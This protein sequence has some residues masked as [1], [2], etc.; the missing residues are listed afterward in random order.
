MLFLYVKRLFILNIN[1][2]L[3][4]KIDYLKNCGVNVSRFEAEMLLAEAIGIERKD[5]PL[6]K[7]SL[8]NEIL[9]RF[10]YFIAERKKHKPVDK[11]I[12]QKGFYKYDFVV[13]EDVL[14]PRFDTEILVEKAV[15]LLKGNS[16]AKILEF[17]VGSGC[18]LL[19]VLADL[20]NVSGIGADISSKALEIAQKN[21]KNLGLEQRVELVNVSW[22]DDKITDIGNQQF[23]MIISNPPYIPSG[24][25]D[26]LDMEV[27]LF[28]PLIALDGG[29]DGLRDYR[30]I[31]KVAY[32]MLKNGG[33]LI[34]EAG[35][36]QA[37]DIV[38]IGKSANFEFVETAN[39]LAGIERCI[40]FKK[41]LHLTKV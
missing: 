23:D 21:A 25:I 41:S 11:I 22:F 16:K 1:A 20:P 35:I 6:W 28:D 2:L 31:A 10:D 5:I 13:S 27:K 39:D 9:Q 14:S 15:S 30:Q 17:G 7:G 24:D 37:Q 8:T 3:K 40:I 26:S 12:G 18:I 32:S 34:F 29:K 19:S 33:F 38:D 36:G 4:E